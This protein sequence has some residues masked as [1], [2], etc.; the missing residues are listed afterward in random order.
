MLFSIFAGLISA[1]LEFVGGYLMLKRRV[2]GWWLLAFGLVLSILGS[3][4][5]REPLRPGSRAGYRLHPPGGQ[6]EL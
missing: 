6:A 1:A 2:T 4:I 3:L 5:R